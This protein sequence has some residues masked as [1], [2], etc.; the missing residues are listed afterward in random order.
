MIKKK[1]IGIF[2]LILIIS[3]LTISEKTEI[4]KH[5]NSKKIT[6]FLNSIEQDDIYG[7]I[8]ESELYSKFK[9]LVGNES[10]IEFSGPAYIESEGRGLHAGRNVRIVQLEIPITLSGLFFSYLRFPRYM[11]GIWLI[12][13]SYNDENATTKIYPLKG[14]LKIDE[15]KSINISG[16]HMILCGVFFF[17]EPFRTRKRFLKP[18]ISKLTGIPEEN[19]TF[20][21]EKFHGKNFLNWATFPYSLFSLLQFYIPLKVVVPLY[22][23]LIPLTFRGYSPFVLWVNKN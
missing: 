19:I 1:I 2:I 12:F 3:P 16:K 14:N 10:K 4:E 5:T 21:I 9:D 18:I 6:N 7:N 11:M 20:P 23:F 8:I 15:N 17:R 22:G 13:A